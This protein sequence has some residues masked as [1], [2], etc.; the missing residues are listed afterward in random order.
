MHDKYRAAVFTV[1]QSTSMKIILTEI[2]EDKVILGC[3]YQARSGKHAATGE[4]A[5]DAVGHLV[6]ARGRELGI[7]VIMPEEK[8]QAPKKK[9]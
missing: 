4:S 7:T 8:K 3:K 2:P 9:K 6:M 1:H 5:S